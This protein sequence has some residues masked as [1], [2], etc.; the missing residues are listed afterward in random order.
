MDCQ[1]AIFAFFV[2]FAWPTVVVAVEV[3]VVWCV[4]KG[5]KELWSDARA[6]S[7]ACASPHG[8]CV[9]SAAIR[10]KLNRKKPRERE[11]VT[12]ESGIIFKELVVMVPTS[13]HSPLSRS[14]PPPL[15]TSAAVLELGFSL[16]ARVGFGLMLLCCIIRVLS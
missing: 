7:T 10:H 12:G 6:P 14:L 9:V 13:A 4:W 11:S 8:S 15:A 5:E 16:S 2:Y 3:F 1:C